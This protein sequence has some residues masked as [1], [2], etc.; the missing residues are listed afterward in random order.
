M[1]QTSAN[2]RKV[3]VTARAFESTLSRLRTVSERVVYNARA[4]PWTARELRSQLADAD[5]AVCFMTD[6]IDA[7]A[8]PVKAHAFM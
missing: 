8:L 4:E 5:A 1:A 3:V 2:L 6:T 7:A